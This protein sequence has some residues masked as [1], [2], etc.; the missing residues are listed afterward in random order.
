MT[1]S[2]R[3][4]APPRFV[5][6]AA[7]DASPGAAGVVSAGIGF[8]QFV[9]GSELHVLHVIEHSPVSNPLVR[10]ATAVTQMNA[11]LE[12]ARAHL[13][14]HL[15]A[16]ADRRVTRVTGHISAGTASIEILRAASSLGADLVLVGTHGRTGLSRMVLGSVAESIVRKASCPVVVVRPKDYSHADVPEIEPPCPQCLETQRATQGDRLWCE[17]HSQ[18]HPRAHTVY[19]MPASFGAGSMLIR[20]E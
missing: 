5:V 16:A 9:P 10:D 13:E 12:D 14:R 15:R 1:A 8:A 17:R 2:T 19:E 4:S 6:L 3:P 20:S 11:R 7:V 18:P